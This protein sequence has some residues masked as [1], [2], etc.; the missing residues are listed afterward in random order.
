MYN[1]AAKITFENVHKGW[2]ELVV[3]GKFLAWQ[4]GQ[5]SEV[6]AL[7]HSPDPKDTIQLIDL[8]YSDV[9]PSKWIH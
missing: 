8:Y 9:N 1:P 7:A 6:Q 2:E 3:T 5:P 4:D